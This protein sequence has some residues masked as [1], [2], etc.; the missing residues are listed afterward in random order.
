MTAKDWLVLSLLPGLGPKRIQSLRERAPECLESWPEGWLALLPRPAATALRLWL[1]HPGRSPLSSSVE[2]LDSWL[3]AAPHH[4]LLHPDH[5]HWPALL[6][7]LPDPPPVLWASGDLAALRPPALAIVGSRRPTR[8]GL[9]SAAEFGRR[10]A[11][12][13]YGIISGLALGIDGA[14]QRAALDA[15]GRSVAVLGCG[16]DVVYPP[17]H[18]ALHRRLMADSG[19]LLSEHPPGTQARA[20]FFPRRNRIVTGLSLGV[21]VVEAAEK[22]GSLVS[23]RLA[24]EQNREVFALPGSVHN[25]QARGCLGLIRQG[26]TLVTCI[27]DIL[28]ELP[29]QPVA[30]TAGSP[31]TALRSDS[32]A[33]VSATSEAGPEDP[34]LALLSD[35]PTPLD[36]LI[37]LTGLDVGSCQ[38]RLLEFEIE[39]LATQAVGGWIR[40][41]Q[42]RTQAR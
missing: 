27:D 12:A 3:A 8:D 20:A 33:V 13:G 11:E 28:D 40:L 21:L 36:V 23:A 7:Q 4:T 42:T 17:R 34:L 29:P 16:V 38:R 19:L 2:A 6:D 5:P 25:P 41:T 10:L 15:G 31:S 1:D 32:G 30:A 22:S 37:E 14:A 35:R 26:A 9:D 24:M 39:G 18:E